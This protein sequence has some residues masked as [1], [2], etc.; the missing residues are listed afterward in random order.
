MSV[1]KANRSVSQMEFLHMARELE[2]YTIKKCTNFPKRYRPLFTQYLTESSYRVYDYV[3]MAN[4][5]YPQN[6]HEAQIRRD[7]LL[8]ARSQL[9]SMISQLEVAQQLF[10][11]PDN[12]MEYW[13]GLIA[14]EL[15][16]LKGVLSKDSA[17][18]KNLK[19]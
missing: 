8:K 5:V 11:L 14:Q 4:S 12:V 16:L 10:E 2:I 18:Y 9:R 15:D 13:V 7:Y 17:R 19:E 3:V 1:I 6:Q